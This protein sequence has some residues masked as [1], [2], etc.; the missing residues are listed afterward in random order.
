MASPTP[1][2]PSATHVESWY[3]SKTVGVI[4]IN[5]PRVKNSINQQTYS[6]LNDALLFFQDDANVLVVVLTGEGDEYFSSGTDV[7]EAK[8]G[9]VASRTV[10]RTL[11]TTIV[12]F[13]KILIGAIN[14]HAIGIGVT[15]LVYCDFVFSVPYATFRTPFLELG[16]VPEF[17]SSLTFPALFGK[18]AA[19]DLLLRCKTLDANRALA[20]GL[21]TEIVPS[22]GFR[23]TVLKL[24]EDI[25]TQL[26]AKHSLLTFKEQMGRLGPLTKQQI[27]ATIDTEFVEIDRRYRTGEIFELGKAYVAQL[28]QRKNASKL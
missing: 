12:N 4:K 5:R 28:K 7:N 18:V 3:A 2:I 11:M 6:E 10:T 22:L 24:T 8:P 16:I 20:V 17:G 21:V 14:G 13:P 26:H 27:F 15:M 23:E 19:N 1:V 9:M 25:T